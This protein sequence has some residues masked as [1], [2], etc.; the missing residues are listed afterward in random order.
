MIEG[1]ELNHEEYCE[2]GF[3]YMWMWC[4]V[5]VLKAISDISP[6]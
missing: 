5:N 4:C 2:S 3:L 6:I 1:D